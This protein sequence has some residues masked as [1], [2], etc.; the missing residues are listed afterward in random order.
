MNFSPY[1]LWRAWRRAAPGHF[2]VAVA[3]LQTQ[4]KFP[5]VKFTLGVRDF[6]TS[7]KGTTFTVMK[8]NI[9]AFCD[10]LLLVAGEAFV[11][12]RPGAPMEDFTT[13]L[14]T[15]GACWSK[16]EPRRTAQVGNVRLYMYR[17]E[18]DVAILFSS[19]RV[20]RALHA[21]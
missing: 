4:C 18:P 7:F 12:A 5:P 17:R 15:H 13:W 20:L 9:I 11:L 2:G 3:Q 10:T 14:K 8:R 1:R 16:M 21:L 19:I 6:E